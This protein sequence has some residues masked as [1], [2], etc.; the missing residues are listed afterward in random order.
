M[1]FLSP[2]LSTLTRAS[3][4]EIHPPTGSQAFETGKDVS[5]H[6]P[7]G[8]LFSCHHA[9]FPAFLLA[10][11]GTSTHCLLLLFPLPYTSLDHIAR[12]LLQG[13]EHT[14]LKFHA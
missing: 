11:L 2:T 9:S 1:G 3:G 4:G 12:V 14:S 13:P 7:R 6:P 8:P 5:E 10:V